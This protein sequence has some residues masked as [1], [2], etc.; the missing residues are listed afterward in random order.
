MMYQCR[1]SGHSHKTYDLISR[2]FYWPKMSDHVKAYVSSCDTCQHNKA[3]HQSQE[4]ITVTPCAN[5]KLAT[6]INE[7]HTQLPKTK[8]HKDA[9]VVFEN[10]LSKQAHF[11]A[12]TTNITAPETA[13]YLFNTIY[14]LHGLPQAIVCNRDTRLPVIS[15]KVYSNCLEQK[16]QCPLPLHPQTDGQTKRTNRTLE[17]I[18]GI[19]FLTNKMIGINI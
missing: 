2:N 9:I 6:N 16:F 11:E 14:R 12:I 8:N 3:T 1:T 4:D 13:K 19:M 17:Q 5:P 7:L 10:R 18:L 15:G